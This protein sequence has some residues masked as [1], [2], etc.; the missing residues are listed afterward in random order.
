MAG[1]HGSRAETLPRTVPNE[2]D[3]IVEL[4]TAR[5]G[6]P[7][8]LAMGNGVSAT[9]LILAA[10]RIDREHVPSDDREWRVFWEAPCTMEVRARPGQC[11]QMHQ[12]K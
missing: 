5:T 2:T 11:D 6:C 7:G 3:S 9:D 10:G 1:A 12:D 8:R 4:V